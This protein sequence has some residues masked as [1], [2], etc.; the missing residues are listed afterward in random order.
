MANGF[1]DFAEG[2]ASTFAPT[3][4]KAYQSAVDRQEDT[5]KENVKSFRTMYK[6]YTDAEKENKE[7]LEYAASIASAFNQPSEALPDIAY[8]I[9]MRGADEVFSDFQKGYTFTPQIESTP[10]DSVEQTSVAD[11]ANA[12]ANQSTQETSDQITQLDTKPADTQMDELGLSVEKPKVSSEDSS[13]VK[14]GEQQQSVDSSDPLSTFAKLRERAGAQQSATVRN[15]TIARLGISEDL[16]DRVMAGQ[17]ETN[18]A[19]TNKFTLT[20]PTKPADFKFTITDGKLTPYDMNDPA[21]VASYNNAITAG[22]IPTTESGAAKALGL[23]TKE[24]VTK[25]SLILQN[26]QNSEQYQTA[27]REE[28]YLLA[29]QILV[30]S[31]QASKDEDQLNFGTGTEAAALS[32]YFNTEKGKKELNVPNPDV[33]IAEKAKEIAA[34]LKPADEIDF[35]TGSLAF[36]ME[37]WAKTNAGKE[38]LANNDFEAIATKARELKNII[39]PKS[40]SIPGSFEAAVV[41][42]VLEDPVFQNL[43]ENNDIVG[44]MELLVAGKRVL[45]KPTKAFTGTGQTT[46]LMNIWAESPAG[47]AALASG[48]T[49]AIIEQLGSFANALNKNEKVEFDSKDIS[50]SLFTMWSRSDEGQAALKSQDNVAIQRAIVSTEQQAKNIRNSIF[51]AVGFDPTAININSL[52]DIVPLREK[53]KDDPII[54]AQ[55]D[56]MEKEFLRSKTLESAAGRAPGK[57]EVFNAYYLGDDGVVSIGTVRRK[58]SDGMFYIGE[59]K[60]DIN[61]ERNY[62]FTPSNAPITSA[63]AATSEITKTLNRLESSISFADNALLYVRRLEA[64]PE[65][66]TAVMAL[67]KN[68]DEYINE[69]ETL[70]RLGKRTFKN[71]QGVDTSFIDYNQTINAIQNSNLPREVKII[72]AQEARLIFEL[73][74]ANGVTGTALSNKD[75][76]AFYNSIFVSNDPKVVIQAIRDSVATSVGSAV[77][78]AKGID[79][80]VGMKFAVNDGAQWWKNPLEHALR[81]KNLAVQNFVTSS[82]DQ[83]TEIQMGSS[84]GPMTPEKLE[85]ML[86]SGQKVVITQEMIDATNPDGTPMF[87]KLQNQQPGSI[88]KKKEK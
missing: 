40:E 68:V 83:R 67:Y 60:I 3:Y 49:T 22:A 64:T 7:A 58:S 50:G 44:A 43:I 81:N 69:F 78:A 15:Q 75:Y 2:F 30:D 53:Y 41:K 29:N 84:F 4:S 37:A 9:K 6:Q 28:D 5:I 63:R 39:D 88:I 12:T 24:K 23:G 19:P 61:E 57:D 13:G 33:V 18:L 45:D 48:D 36:A 87:P 25:E 1:D 65:A 80:E 86:G 55:L 14:K 32:A 17:F 11:D 20:A 47:K 79:D 8:Q 70:T 38:V 72:R 16:F 46:D 34:T 76:M 62:I 21:A 52:Q 59:E 51:Q 35:G 26:V 71:D 85:Q 66:R 27:I 54:L 31:F 74:A 56:R 77:E 42:T 10:N 73:A 82:L